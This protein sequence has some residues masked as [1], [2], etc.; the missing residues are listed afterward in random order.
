[1]IINVVTIIRYTQAGKR[2]PFND[3]RSCPCGGM[4]TATRLTS[5]RSPATFYVLV[6]A[7]AARMR[8]RVIRVDHWYCGSRVDGHRSGLS[9]LATNVANQAI[10]EY[11]RASPNISIGLKIMSSDNEVMRRDCTYVRTQ[12]MTH[13]YINIDWYIV[14]KEQ[15]LIIYSL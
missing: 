14:K 5:S 2:A 13:A 7:R 6:I 11:T 3:R 10:L 1:M 15:E 4:R 8:V 12:K 9:H